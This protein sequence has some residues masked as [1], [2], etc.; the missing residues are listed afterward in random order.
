MKTPKFLDRIGERFLE[1][2]L[3]DAVF[4]IAPRALTGVRVLPRERSVGGRFV[5]TLP[6]GAVRPAFEGKNVGD[7]AF[8]ESKVR[9]GMLK[10]GLAQGTVA[11]LIPE[12]CARVFLLPVDSSPGSDKERDRI[13]RWRIGKMM[14]SL[15]EDAR[16]VHQSLSSGNGERIVAA[17]ARPEVVREYEGLFSRLGL[18]PGNVSLPSLSLVGLLPAGGEDAL[19]VNVE[20]D[21]LSLTA[22]VGAEPVLFRQ[23]PFALDRDPGTPL[24]L[25]LGPLV[26]E[27]EN[28]ALFLEDKEKKTVRAVW[29]RASSDNGDD[30]VAELGRQLSLPIREMGSVVPGDAGAREKTLLSTLYGHL[31]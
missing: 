18:V 9:E 10:L 4:Q 11:V 30:L 3:P 12:L 22:V 24:G 26:R 20:D 19:V 8:L 16:F 23:K 13:V 21:S 2:P 27:I 7:P 29:L 1:A 25:R 14:P 31:A 17:V 28:T 5:A 15:P 6:D